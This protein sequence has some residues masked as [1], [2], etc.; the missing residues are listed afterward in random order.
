M[1]QLS[2]QEF[3]GI[4]KIQCWSVRR[5]KW[6]LFL[7]FCV[8][9]KSTLFYFVMSISWVFEGSAFPF[10]VV[11]TGKKSQTKCRCWAASQGV[12]YTGQTKA[13]EAN[14][15][16]LFIFIYISWWFCAWHPRLTDPRAYILT[17]N[18]D[19]DRWERLYYFFIGKDKSEPY[20]CRFPV[21]KN[22]CWLYK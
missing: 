18:M 19:K 12:E 14:P 5:Y 3:F 16:G 4:Q 1:K 20:W 2:R 8:S 13:P 10:P 11:F 9:L 17:S 6:A 21:G 22:S 7:G 15:A